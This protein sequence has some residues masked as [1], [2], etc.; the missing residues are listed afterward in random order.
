MGIPAIYQAAAK[1]TG[2]GDWSIIEVRYDDN[3]TTWR[4]ADYD[5]KYAKKNTIR[6]EW[7]TIDT[8]IGHNSKHKCIHVY[9]KGMNNRWIWYNEANGILFMKHLLTHSGRKDGKDGRTTPV[10]GLER[11]CREIN[12]D[13]SNHLLCPECKTNCSACKG[14]GKTP[15]SEGVLDTLKEKFCGTNKCSACNGTGGSPSVSVQ[16]SN[17]V[18]GTLKEGYVP[19]FPSLVKA[20]P[21]LQTVSA[22]PTAHGPPANGRRLAT[23]TLT[24]SEEA[25]G[26]RRLISRP[27]SHATVLEALLVEINRLRWR[28]RD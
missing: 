27:K 9:I 20:E 24:P 25:L 3:H 2:Y 14:T 10:S 1:V 18:C 15:G 23:A 17:A 13:E 26:R 16:C 7:F 11:V 22:P 5:H 28:S 6:A 19:P 8:V 4:L 21:A 12:D